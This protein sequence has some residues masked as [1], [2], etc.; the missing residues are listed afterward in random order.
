MR[1]EV[2]ALEAVVEIPFVP[3]FIEIWAG[4]EFGIIEAKW[5]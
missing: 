3:S 4:A 1:D 2:Q 5:W